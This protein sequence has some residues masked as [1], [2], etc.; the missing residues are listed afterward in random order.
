[1]SYLSYGVP[2]ESA[3]VEELPRAQDLT[4]LVGLGF[5]ISLSPN[6]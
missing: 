1:M 4:E 3:H 2:Y 6:L 5:S